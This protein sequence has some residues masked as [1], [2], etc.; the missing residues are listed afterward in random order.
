M[1]GIPGV[2]RQNGGPDPPAVAIIDLVAV[3]FSLAR[4][5]YAGMGPAV[6]VSVKPR[7]MPYVFRVPVPVLTW[8]QLVKGIGGLEA[9]E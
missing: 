2:L 7:G 8:A 3:D 6:L 4:I 5:D 9:V 1:S